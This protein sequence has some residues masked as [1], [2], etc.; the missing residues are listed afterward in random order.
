MLK[1]QIK[2]TILLMVLISV[3]VNHAKVVTVASK[4][5]LDNTKNNVTKLGK[6]DLFI[7]LKFN[8]PSFILLFFK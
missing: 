5:E 6:F 4:D 3:Y 7:F 2:T 8:K 1:F